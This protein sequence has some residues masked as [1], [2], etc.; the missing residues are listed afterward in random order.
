MQSCAPRDR[1]I[2]R[3]IIP[4]ESFRKHF[5]GNDAIEAWIARAIHLADS[6]RAG[7]DDLVGA[8]ADAAAE[9]HARDYTR[10]T[11]DPWP[12]GASTR[13]RDGLGHLGPF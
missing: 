8:Q 3:G 12:Q 9:R 7:R 5:D 11:V 1:A 10:P 13:E 2:P 6:A 4:R